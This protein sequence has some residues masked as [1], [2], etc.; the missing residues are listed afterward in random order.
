MER[1]NFLRT[2]A[3]AVA[4]AQAAVAQSPRPTLNSPA[5]TSNEPKRK[6]T[7]HCGTQH[8][9]AEEV[10]S[11]MSSLGVNHICSGEIAPQL[12]ENWSVEGLSRLRERVEKHGIK[13]E[14]VPVPLPSAAIGKAPMGAV[15]MGK[16]PERDRQIEQIQ[17][18]LRNCAAAGIPAV[19]YNMSILGVVRLPNRTKGRGEST[20][21][22]WNYKEAPDKDKLTEA[23]VVSADQYWERIDYYLSRVVPVANEVKVRMACHPHDPGMPV[24][25]G[26]RGVQTVL[27]S[28]AG[29]KKFVAMHESPYHGLNFCQGTVSEMLEDP[30]K[31][32]HDL[33]RYFG[34]RK[35]IFN[36]HF[37]NIHGKFSDFQETFPDAGSVNMIE[38][39]RTYQ[40]V[41]YPYML[42]P[43]HV[44]VIPGDKGGAQAFAFAFGYIQALIQ[45]L[46]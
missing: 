38:A 45:M 27:G 9:H 44:P 43:D 41:G 21:S 42:M 6:A 37:R 31:E 2:A 16:S 34:S 26:Y 29:L 23:G 33:I 24:P 25:D 15:M 3:G 30:N 5:L 4:L 17:Q 7:M 19:K 35:K 22:T 8:S 10:L 13:L 20:Y 1:R 28:P 11:A 12:D 46:G 40:E 14:M 32:I 18:M 39:I 36:V